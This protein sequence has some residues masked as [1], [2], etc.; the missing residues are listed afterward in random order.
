M[1]IYVRGLQNPKGIVA[2]MRKE[3]VQKHLANIGIALVVMM[4]LLIFAASFLPITRL[5]DMIFYAEINRFVQ[6]IMSLTLLVIAWNLHLR[7][8]FAWTLCIIVLSGRLLLNFVLHHHAAS[9]V[10]VAFEALTL[11]ALLMSYSRFKRPSDRL[12]VKRSVLVA[13]IGL[14]SVLIGAAIGRFNL[15]LHAGERLSFTDSLV[16]TIGIIFGEN[17][18][19]PV[20]DRFILYFAWICV[21]ASVILILHS[22]IISKMK[23]DEERIQ[24]RELVIKYGQNSS[25]YLI[26]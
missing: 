15:S 23:T 4:S 8:R 1:D 20:Y 16:E 11:I 26:L 2:S 6:R 18:D 19:F 10:V 14:F 5:H 7:K 3:T 13:V 21:V 24:A 25:S 12:S 17:V 22:A 9:L